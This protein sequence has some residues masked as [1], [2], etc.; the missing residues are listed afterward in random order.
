ME[1]QESP[2]TSEELLEAKA[3]ELE[4]MD[5]ATSFPMVD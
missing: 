2:N 5:P 3:T 1:V 4:T